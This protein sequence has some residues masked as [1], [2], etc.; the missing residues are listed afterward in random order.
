MDYPQLQLLASIV[1]Y[2]CALLALGCILW[3]GRVHGWKAAVL[4]LV[5]CILSALAGL[6][7]R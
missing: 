2:G 7:H 4:A 6:A 5:A 3:L 1:S